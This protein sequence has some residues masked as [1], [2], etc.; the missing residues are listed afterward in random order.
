[1]EGWLII[2][3]ENIIA[4]QRKWTLG[5]IAREIDGIKRGWGI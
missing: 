2:A 5:K 3:W 1:V 4:R